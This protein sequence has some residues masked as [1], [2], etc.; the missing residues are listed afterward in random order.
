MTVPAA[1]PKNVTVNRVEAADET[2]PGTRLKYT[3]VTPCSFFHGWIGARFKSRSRSSSRMRI[4]RIVH[5][6]PTRRRSADQAPM[7]RVS[8]VTRPKRPRRWRSGFPIL[9]PGLVLESGPVK[10]L[11]DSLIWIAD[12]CAPFSIRCSHS[13]YTPPT[14]LSFVVR[15]APDCALPAANCQAS[16][17]L[18]TTF[19]G[20]QICRK[21]SPPRSWPGIACS[22]PLPRAMI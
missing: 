7:S 12:Q 9:A 17:G 4:A 22:L 16:L 6:W 10:I 8:S 3:E 2:E 19:C 15:T 13:V 1:H 11:A 20:R 18:K 14:G 5:T 21:G